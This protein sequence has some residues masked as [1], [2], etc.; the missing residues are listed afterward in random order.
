MADQRR[1]DTDGGAK[2]YI[3]DYGADVRITFELPK[4]I[5]PLEKS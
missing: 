4:G 2:G 3:V 5:V 1:S